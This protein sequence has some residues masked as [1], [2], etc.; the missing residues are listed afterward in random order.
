MIKAK[1]FGV[2]SHGETFKP[3]EIERRE[4]GENDVMIKI[5]YCGICH[6]DVHQVRN[7]WGGSSYP[8]VPGHEIVGKITAVGKYSRDLKVG[9][10]VGVGCM[11]DSCGECQSCKSGYE[12]Q[13]DKE[14]VWTY[15]SVDSLTGKTTF[16]G[17]SDIITVNS[18]FVIRIGTDKDLA[19]IAPILCAGVTTYS[20]LKKFGA[21][22]GKHVAVVGLGGLGHMAVKLARAM[23]AEVTVL[24][25][26]ESKQDDARRL[27]ASRSIVYHNKEDIR[28]SG[29]SFDIIVDTIPANHDINT[30]ISTLKPNGTLVLVGLPERSVKYSLSPPILMDS[31]RAIAG[32]NIG[33]IPETQAVIDFCV[34]NN[35][36]SDIE[37]ISFSYLDKAYERIMNND[38]KYRFVIDNSTI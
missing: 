23:G 22:P 20:P 17:Y 28:K 4:V 37:L 8:I 24:T 6:S 30:L 29:Y 32:S 13:C 19:G 11:V 26:S 35:I 27:G 18:R 33:G 1:G 15:N 25:S 2:K 36:R 14:T 16:G 34:K 9:D 10:Y 21:G 5:L 31:N 3:L 7:D 12:Q 38:V